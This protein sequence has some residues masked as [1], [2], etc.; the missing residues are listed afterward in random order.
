VDPQKGDY[1]TSIPTPTGIP[2]DV[3]LTSYGVEQS[4]E[5]AEH[6]CNADPPID[7]IYSSP[8]YRCLQTLKPTTDRLFAES[9]AGG[10]VRIDHGLGEFYGKAAFTHPTPPDLAMLGP[11]FTMLDQEY[12]SVHLPHVNGELIIE[13]HDRAKKAI[14]HIVEKL[15]SDIEKPKTLLICTHAAVMIALG[16]ALTG[17]MPQDLDED[18]FQCHTASLSTFKRKGS[19][20]DGVLGQWDCIGNAETHF[21]KGGPERGW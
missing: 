19:E 3:P 10:K 7:R 15:D 12:A 14:E 4:K 2:T 5:L 1:T 17:N 6:L 9:K 13:L 21:L 18:D 16:R 11:H 8:F 20:G